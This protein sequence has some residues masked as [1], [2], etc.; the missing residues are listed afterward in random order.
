MAST[1]NS[2][3]LLFLRFGY[4]LERE[5]MAA[6][7]LAGADVAPFWPER[8]AAAGRDYPAALL[9]QARTLRPDAVFGINFLGGDTDGALQELL[10]RLGIRFATWF[11]D[12]PEL[13]LHGMGHLAA[14][15]PILFCCD[16]DAESKLAP[17]G[18]TDIHP[19]P[20]AAD[21]TRF[22]L[23]ADV[24][25]PAPGGP[26][27]CFVGHSWVDKIG[28]TLKNFRFPREVL[29]AYRRAGRALADGDYRGSTLDALHERCPAFAASLENLSPE[30][31]RGALHLACWEGNRAY[32]L[33]CVS[34]LTGFGPTV[35]GDAHW[36][37]Q[38]G[39][40]AE[41]VRLH[42]PVGYYT[43]DLARLYRASA[44]NFACSGVQMPGAV[45]QRAF[46]VP[47]A[48]GF[49]LA[50]RRRQM[51]EL[52]EP[53]V[54][55]TCFERPEDIP[56]AVAR[57]QRDP[58]AARRILAAARKRIVAEHTYLHRARRILTVLAQS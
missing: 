57:Y 7:T 43:P 36:T 16:P 28:L 52:F 11:V 55:S 31:R 26:P 42:P 37:R 8:E 38:L 17:M 4:F 24:A 54:E 40:L 10:N 18:F 12:S 2:P 15:R 45:T 21:A 47:A 56:Q 27:V 34:R 3:R 6:F 22:D 25:P 32:R 44:V 51:D 49:L 20:L 48:G 35:V 46:D 58:D 23:T 9:E 53:G 33:D 19:L 30:D 14:A 41:Q 39:P 13:F 1:R 50:D 5:L 29:T